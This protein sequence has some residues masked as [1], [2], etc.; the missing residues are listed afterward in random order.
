LAAKLLAAKVL[1]EIDLPGRFANRREERGAERHMD[2]ELE[3]AV[4]KAQGLFRRPGFL[5]RRLHQIYVALYL[6][7]CEQFGTTPVQSSVLQVL[8][9]RPGL[10]QATLA[11]EIGV[12]RTTTSDV[13]SRLEKRGLV[14]R[15]PTEE[16][17]RLRRAFLTSAG[18]AMVAEMQAALDNAHRRLVQ[19]L[20]PDGRE[21][22]VDQLVLLVEANNEQGRATLRTS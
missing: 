2:R 3:A 17:R 5:V 1:A 12:D 6:Q 9:L 11:A 7:E 22:F 19:A 16:D 10:D 14:E 8:L 21:R 18:A 15:R 20:P 13:L 4:R